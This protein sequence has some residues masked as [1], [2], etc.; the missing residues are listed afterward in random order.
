VTICFNT[1][2]FT[3]NNQTTSR[4]LAKAFEDCELD[5]W[6]ISP[7]NFSFKPFLDAATDIPAG[8]DSSETIWTNWIDRQPI[9][10]QQ[11][12]L[13][14]E[15]ETQS[16]PPLHAVTALIQWLDQEQLNYKLNM[17]YRL[18]NNCFEGQVNAHRPH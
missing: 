9:D 13:M 12:K 2:N 7:Q 8:E 18:E 10:N 15:F 5:D 16:E 11:E 3:A 1:I 14:I 6:G 17:T 4:L